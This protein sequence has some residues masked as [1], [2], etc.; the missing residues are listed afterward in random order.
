MIVASPSL[1]L[2]FEIRGRAKIKLLL[3]FLVAAVSLIGEYEP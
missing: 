3:Q 1:A 2:R